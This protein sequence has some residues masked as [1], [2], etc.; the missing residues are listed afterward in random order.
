[1]EHGGFEPPTPCL[2]EKWFTLHGVLQGHVARCTV[3][4][5]FRLDTHVGPAA[6]RI[7]GQFLAP[8]SYRPGWP[9][10]VSCSRA[11][12][13]VCASYRGRAERAP[14][15]TWSR[16]ELCGNAIGTYPLQPAP[17]RINS[18]PL[19]TG[20][21]VGPLF[22]DDAVARLPKAS[23]ALPRVEKCRYRGAYGPHGVCGMIAPEGRVE[24]IR[25][26]IRAGPISILTCVAV[27]HRLR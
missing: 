15:A 16:I 20:E 6:A 3:R 2:P 25:D 12:A 9:C 7:S 26:Q 1:V 8:I 5:P 17:R 19:S 4:S 23:Y 11:Q 22:A 18:P 10:S 14:V 13:C 21:A 27:S 24:H